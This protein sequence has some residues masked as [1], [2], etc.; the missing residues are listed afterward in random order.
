MPGWSPEIANEFIRIA[1]IENRVLNPL[2]LQDLVYVANGWCLAFYDEPLTRDCP[3]AWELGQ[4]YRKL[5][6]AL[7]P[8][9]WQ[10][11]IDEIRNTDAFPDYPG[12]N[13][14]SPARADLQRFERDLVAEV[15]EHFGSLGFRE[16]ASLTS[17]GDVPWGQI[18]ADGAGKC[19]DIPHGLIKAQ[20][21]ELLRQSQNSASPS[22]T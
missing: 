22:E 16:L 12:S 9:G 6:E 21:L 4:M 17:K 13:G 5:A 2:Q 19:R 1:A 15:Y 20:F 7:A 18:F 3:E 8:H 11:V 10:P 14:G